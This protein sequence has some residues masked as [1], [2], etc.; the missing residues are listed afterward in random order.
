M[1]DATPGPDTPSPSNEHKRIVIDIDGTLCT[2]KTASVSYSSVQ[3]DLDVIAKLREYHEDNFYIILYTSRQMRTYQ[4]NV[5]KITAN[6]LPVLIEWLKRYDVPYDEIIIGK[7]WCGFQGFYVDDKAIRPDEF[8]NLPYS[9]I[10]DLLH[11]GD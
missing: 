11:L 4:N 9:G 2:V 8:L 6:T 3:P 7:P 5:G 1:P 10:K